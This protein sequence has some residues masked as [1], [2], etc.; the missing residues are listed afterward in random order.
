MPNQQ[1]E[2]Q[3]QDKRVWQEWGILGVPL[4]A[5]QGTLLHLKPIFYQ[6]KRPF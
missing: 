1:K 5:S 4:I 2:R 6:T 3:I